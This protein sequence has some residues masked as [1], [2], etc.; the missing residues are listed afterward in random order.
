MVLLVELKSTGKYKQALQQ[1][2]DMLK[3]LC[4]KASNG[5][6]HTGNHQT[7]PGHETRD[8]RGIRGYVVLGTGIEVPKRQLERERIRQE[9]GVVVH[10]KTKRLEVNGLDNLP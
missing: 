8:K 4:K 6:I 5:G 7:S 3:R 1:I 9:Y 10:T 2:E